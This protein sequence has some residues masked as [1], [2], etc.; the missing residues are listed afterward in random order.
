M[1]KWTEQDKVSGKPLL[2]PWL[3][4]GIMELI[5]GIMKLFYTPLNV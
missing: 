2:K 5:Y 3:I 4:Y 1:P